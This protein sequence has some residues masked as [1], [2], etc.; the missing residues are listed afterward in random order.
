MAGYNE[1][2]VTMHYVDDLIA[3]HVSIEPVSIVIDTSARDSGNSEGSTILRKGLVLGKVTA[4]GRYK[5]FDDTATDGTENSKDVVI[6]AHEVRG[7]SDGHKAATAYLQGTFKEDG[8]INGGN[9]TWTDVQRLVLTD[10]L[11]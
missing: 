11:G 10:S 9:V 8:V 3:S 7:I 4:S 6:L 2:D 5:E 1:G